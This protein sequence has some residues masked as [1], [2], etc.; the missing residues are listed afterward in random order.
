MNTD[1]NLEI[2]DRIKEIRIQKGI[3]QKDFAKI[4]D[5][6]VSTLANYET[7]RRPVSLEVLNKIADAL[8]VPLYELLGMDHQEVLNDAATKAAFGDLEGYEDDPDILYDGIMKNSLEESYE[9]LRLNKIFK[10]AIYDIFD[11]YYSHSSTLKPIKK[12]LNMSSGDLFKKDKLLF[13]ALTRELG[14]VV[15]A[16]VQYM[17]DGLKEKSTVFS[18]TDESIKVPYFDGDFKSRTG[19]TSSCIKSYELG[20][21]DEDLDYAKFIIF[22]KMKYLLK[23][24]PRDEFIDFVEELNYFMQN[25]SKAGYFNRSEVLNEKIKQ[26][27]LS[28][29]I[30]KVNQWPATEKPL[31]E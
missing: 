1:K 4:L 8:E 6:P 18:K 24:L 22:E 15:K 29:P 17:N 11:Y 14:Y 2:G 12:D 13:N 21:R 5:M 31:T 28:L 19:E 30:K 9:I 20:K 10:D 25:P 16:R 23:E 3:K 26:Q 7:N 27:L